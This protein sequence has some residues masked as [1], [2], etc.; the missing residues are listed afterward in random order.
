MITAASTTQNATTGA[1]GSPNV[2]EDCWVKACSQPG[3]IPFSSLV[4]V[5]TTAPTTTE[6]MPSVTTSGSRPNR[7]HT[8]PE[9]LPPATHTAAT[10]RATSPKFQWS[11]PLKCV[12]SRFPATRYAAIEKS[13]PPSRITNVCPAAATPRNDACSRIGASRP[14]QLK[15]PSFPPT[16]STS[17]ASTST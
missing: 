4:S 9:K 3:A 1:T 6:L 11:S 16:Y 14:F 7:W 12:T 17:A 15:S 10:M 2:V 13:R 8:Q 5:P